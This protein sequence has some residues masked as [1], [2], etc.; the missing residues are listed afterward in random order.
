VKLLLD[1]NVP[2]QAL[3]VLQRTLRSHQVDHVDRLDR[4]G[5]RWK[6]KKDRQL[7]PD[8]ASAG[9]DVFVTKDSNQLA[10]PAETRL[11]K[12]AGI[13]HVRFQQDDGVAGFARAVGA[14]VAAMVDIVTELEGIDGQRLVRI[15][16]LDPKR[17]RHEVVDPEVDPPPYWR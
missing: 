6:G 15:V 5:T 17:R 3:P 1:E 14:L 12:Q 2:L 16:R 13:H 10:D 8:A 7:L 4:R 9:Y 11:I